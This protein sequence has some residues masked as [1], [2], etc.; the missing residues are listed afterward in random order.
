MGSRGLSQVLPGTPDS[1][2]TSLVHVGKYAG[3]SRQ[4][5]CLRQNVSRSEHRWH[6]ESGNFMGAPKH[7]L[8]QACP[9]NKHVVHFTIQAMSRMRPVIPS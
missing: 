8:H 1:P 5:L 4:P 2:E 6:R 3:Q 7:L 9:W